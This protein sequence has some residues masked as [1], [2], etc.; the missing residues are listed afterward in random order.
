MT[1]VVAAV[2]HK[3]QCGR[4]SRPVPICRPRDRSLYNFSEGLNPMPRQYLRWLTPTPAPLIAGSL[5][6]DLAGNFSLPQAPTTLRRG[7]MSGQ[8]AYFG[9]RV[10]FTV[11]LLASLAWLAL[12]YWLAVPW[13][14]DFQVVA[15]TAVAIF[16]VAGIALIPGFMNAFLAVSLLLDRRPLRRRL[17]RYPA[18]TILIAAYN[19]SAAIAETIHSVAKQQY[20]GDL[21]VLVID[22][23]SRDDTAARV[24]AIQYPW[25]KLLRQPRNAGKAAALNRGLAEAHYGLV[26]TLDADCYLYKRALHKLVERY[27]S[28]PAD[29]RAV[30]GAVLVRNSRTNW[31]TK[32]QEWD[33][34]HGIA[35][36]KRTQSFYHGTLVAQGAFSIYDR[37]TL[38]KVGGWPECVGEDI[39]LTWA[40]LR[41]GYRVGHAEDA[42]CFTNAPDRLGQFIR[43][44]QRWSRG[45][46]EA[47]RQ[48]P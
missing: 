16:V 30:A 34:F 43:Q 38:Q 7:E 8:R 39:V 37:A 23:G 17:Y 26:I 5:S 4:S 27:T 41:Q 13:M 47:F 6:S 3:I 11:A 22:D 44:R 48:Y 33:Y 19:E 36:I 46:M 1:V 42:C 18:I 9:V 20:P 2:V 32:V 21:E 35:A 31:V 29:T 24:E 28:D 25:L 12:S 40:I 15:G 10:K 45:M 14:H